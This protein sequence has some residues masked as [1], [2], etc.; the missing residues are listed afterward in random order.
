MSSFLSKSTKS[1]I[2]HPHIPHAVL[3]FLL[4]AHMR[5][6][7]Q[8][9]TQ[10]KSCANF[11]SLLGLGSACELFFIHLLFLAS[12]LVEILFAWLFSTPSSLFY[13]RFFFPLFYSFSNH[14]SSYA[15]TGFMST[16]FTIVTMVY[17]NS[18][19]VCVHCHSIILQTHIYSNCR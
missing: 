2:V 18:V 9:K 8:I 17:Q 14:F 1:Y 4:Y 6:T 11:S 5:H 12:F 13:S 7:A 15:R 16:G 3:E 19:Y 10:K